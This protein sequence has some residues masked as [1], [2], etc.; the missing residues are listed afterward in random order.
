MAEISIRRAT[1]RDIPEIL[2]TLKAALGETQILRRTTEL[3]NWKHHSNPFGSSLVLVAASGDQIAGVRAM[4][5]WQMQT[6]TGDI[7]NA[8][9]PVDTATHPDFVRRGI[10]RDL[11]MNALDI[12]RE[13][14]VDLVFNTPNEKSAPGYLKMGWRDVSGIGVMVRPRFGRS[15]K[16]NRQRPP[17]IEELAPSLDSPSGS[18]DTVDRPARGLRT[19][20]TS[21]YLD[22]RFTQHPTASYG[23]L[24][25]RSGGGLMARANTRSKRTELVVSDLLGSPSSGVV[26]N[27]SRQS[28]ARYLAGWFSPGSPEHRTAI[29]GG[30]VPVPLLRTLRLVA[31]PL[32]DFAIDI[33]DMGSWDLSTSDLELL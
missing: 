32:T 20:R 33:H 30:L 29:A 1:D 24:A 31:M 11:T 15:T 21:A 18:F 23:W 12:A 26:R 25:D 4:M 13:E 19:P 22:W 6:P 2:S 9:R 14:G 3:W 5:R 8:V 27:A 10:F 7:V 28:K 16:P 17:S